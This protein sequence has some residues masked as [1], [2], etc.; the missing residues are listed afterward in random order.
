MSR[1]FVATDAALG[2]PLVLEVLPVELEALVSADRSRRE[3]VIAAHDEFSVNDTLW[4]DADPEL[5][6]LSVQVERRMAQLS[7]QEG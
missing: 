2:R 1:V 3:I 5:R 6:P 4:K 7:N